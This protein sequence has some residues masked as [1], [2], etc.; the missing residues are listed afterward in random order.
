MI[1]KIK[2]KKFFGFSL[3][4]VLIALVVIGIVSAI[5]V[6]T[7]MASYQKNVTIEK[8]K[9]VHSTFAQ[10][11]NRI[12]SDNGGHFC[13][14][15][16]GLECLLFLYQDVKNFKKEGWVAFSKEYLEPYMNLSKSADSTI[17]MQECFSGSEEDCGNSEPLYGFHLVDG[18]TI[19]LMPEVYGNDIIDN[20]LMNGVL[21]VVDINGTGKKPNKFGR[22]LFLYEYRFQDSKDSNNIGRI[23]PFGMGFKENELASYYGTGG[24]TKDSPMFC[25][26]KIVEDGWQIKDD[27]PW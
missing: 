27:Y 17:V 5:T 22:D 2:Y 6:P 26:K 15:H 9:K 19:A 24:C 25:A 3:A 18:T 14:R 7:L 12:I 23:V 4:E 10:V 21:I 11:S 1:L 16:N 13:N 20:T 8:L